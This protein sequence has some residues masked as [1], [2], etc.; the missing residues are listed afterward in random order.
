MGHGFKDILRWFEKD[1]DYFF[2]RI[3][4]TDEFMALLL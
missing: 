2:N 3:I 1:G 4:T